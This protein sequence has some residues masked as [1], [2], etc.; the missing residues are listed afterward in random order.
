MTPA[1]LA[2]EQ[3]PGL[4]AVILKTLIPKIKYNSYRIEVEQETENLVNI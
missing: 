3:P 4:Y 2:F 1:G